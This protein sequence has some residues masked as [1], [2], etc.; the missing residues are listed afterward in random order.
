MNTQ[1]IFLLMMLAAV[2]WTA[3]ASNSPESATD[4]EAHEETEHVRLT[5]T[6]AHGIGMKIT[7]AER[8]L[9]SGQLQVNGRLHVLPQDVAVVTSLIGATVQSITIKEG[10]RVRAGQVLAYLSHPNLIDEQTSFIALHSEFKALEKEYERQKTLFSEQVGSGRALEETAGRYE[11]MKSRLAGQLARLELIGFERPQLEAGTV[12]ERIAVKA[13]INGFVTRIDIK[14]GQY[15]PADAALFEIEN[16][17]HLHADLMIF[18][19]DMQQVREGQKVRL[20]FDAMPGTMVPSE[21]H[22][23]GKTFEDDPK[24][25]HVHA[26]VPNPRGVLLP[27]MYVRA[28]IETGADSSWV[29]PSVAVVRD[30]DRHY[31][32][33]QMDDDPHDHGEE[34]GHDHAEG[35]EDHEHEGE[36]HDDYGHGHAHGAWI[37]MPVEVVIGTESEGFTEIRFLQEV[38]PEARFAANNAYYLMAEMKKGEAGHG[39]DH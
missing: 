3:C 15:V 20:Y 38:S 21:I 4:H 8:R 33:M 11:A 17:D 25:M 1:N 37:F 19:R 36:G 2:L 22:R 27:G 12:A 18:E 29:L 23:I 14:T 39:H 16:L 26:E 24:A 31:V 6:Q 28:T 10:E 5:D 13:R 34:D 9:L 30:G 32:F 7:T 35:E